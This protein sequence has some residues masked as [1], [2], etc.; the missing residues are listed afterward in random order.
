MQQKQRGLSQLKLCSE[1]ACLFSTENRSIESRAYHRIPASLTSK[2]KD[3]LQN[4]GS[5]TE[6][7][8]EMD[9]LELLEDQLDLGASFLPNSTGVSAVTETSDLDLLRLNLQKLL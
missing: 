7:R 3:C 8:S 1:C 4:G 6:A 2:C 5:E 9:F